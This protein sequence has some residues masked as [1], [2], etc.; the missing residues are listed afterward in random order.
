MRS[1]ALTHALEDGIEEGFN[2]TEHLREADLSSLDVAGVV[3]G[4]LLSCAVVA[5]RGDAMTEDAFLD[6]AREG[7]RAARGDNGDPLMTLI[8][9][10]ADDG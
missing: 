3:G 9:N 6:M 2:M 5:S 8:E 1:C 7:Y 10:V 4:W